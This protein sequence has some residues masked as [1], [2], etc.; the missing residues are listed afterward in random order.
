MIA[1]GRFQVFIHQLVF[2]KQPRRGCSGSI[3]AL[4]FICMREMGIP[5]F[6]RKIE[7][8][9]LEKTPLRPSRRAIVRL[10]AQAC[11]GWVPQIRQR[12]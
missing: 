5:G 9:W 2:S 12:R 10:D 3:V 6:P 1:L 11:Q 4:P 8:P 7:I